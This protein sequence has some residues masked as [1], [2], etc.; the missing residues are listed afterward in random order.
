MSRT[1]KIEYIT[2]KVNKRNYNIPDIVLNPV[3]WRKAREL[4]DKSYKKP[5]AYK[6][7]YITKKYKDLGGRFKCCNETKTGLSRWYKEKWVNQRGEVGYKKSG[8]IYRP[9]KKITK[10]TPTTWNELSKKQIKKASSIK[11]KKG[12][13][14]KFSNL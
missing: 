6:S 3:L 11:K 13:V 1:N 12:R 9:T 8:D 4:A 10:K 5:S 2:N 7:G 14:K